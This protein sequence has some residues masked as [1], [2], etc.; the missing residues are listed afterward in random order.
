MTFALVLQLYCHN[1]LCVAIVLWQLRQ[2][3][4]YRREGCNELQISQAYHY[5]REGE[6]LSFYEILLRA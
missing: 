2:V 5:L 3:D 1:C 6:E 4:I